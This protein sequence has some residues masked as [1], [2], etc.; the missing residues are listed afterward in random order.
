MPCGSI[1]PGAVFPVI[2]YFKTEKL[3]ST[4]L[5]ITKATGQVRGKFVS[6]VGPPRRSVVETRELVFLGFVAGL[7]LGSISMSMKTGSCE[8][9]HANRRCLSLF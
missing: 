1:N 8:L 5:L 2:P 9:S 6:T 4:R 7:G 3:I